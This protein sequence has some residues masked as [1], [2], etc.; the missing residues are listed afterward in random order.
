LKWV[1]LDVPPERGVLGLASDGEL[2]TQGE[3]RVWLAALRLVNDR[4][5]RNGVSAGLQWA[6]LPVHGHAW[7]PSLAVGQVASSNRQPPLP[8]L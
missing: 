3:P 6:G 1:G 5:R 2:A 7:S 4:K 8:Q